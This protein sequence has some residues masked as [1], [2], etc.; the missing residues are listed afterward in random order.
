MTRIYKKSYRVYYEDTDAGGVVY[1][2]NYLK[3]AERAR[4]EM[5]R[6]H[7]INQHDLAETD[8]LY[9][10]VRKTELD[11]QKAAKLDDLLEI[12]TKLLKKSGATM[13]LEQNITFEKIKICSI[14][15]QL[16]AVNKNFKPCRLPEFCHN[17]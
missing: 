14:K 7:G 12:E 9:F 5:L 6:E 10:V 8:N 16:V 17:L 13:W 1:Y 11:I 3:F 4:T 2:A 15:V